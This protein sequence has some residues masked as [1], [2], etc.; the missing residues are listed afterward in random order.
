LSSLLETPISGDMNLFRARGP[1]RLGLGVSFTS[2]GMRAPYVNGLEWGLQQTYLSTTRMLRTEGS[3]RPYIQVRGGFAR[4]HPRSHLFD[5]HT[6]REGY[7]LGGSTTRAANGFG[8]GVIPG[9]EWN[10]NRSVA[11]DLSAS[12]NYFD[13]GDYDLSPSA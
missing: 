11:L 13:V 4:L 5:E 6:L 2:F 8:V 7:V 9:L 1:W 10:L 3:F 12:F